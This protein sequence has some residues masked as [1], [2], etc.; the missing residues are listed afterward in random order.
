[1]SFTRQPANRQH[2]FTL[3]EL[4]IV[5]VI[6]GIIASVA[7][8]SYT[9]YVERSRLSDGKAGLMQAASEMERCYTSNYSYPSDCFSDR[10]S[11]EGVYTITIFQPDS[12]SASTYRIKATN[13]TNVPANCVELWIESDGD[14]GPDDCW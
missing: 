3:I 11:P 10:P 8:P 5:V 1:M 9:R 12:G 4:M 6:I 14:R 7:Y 13:G 2:G